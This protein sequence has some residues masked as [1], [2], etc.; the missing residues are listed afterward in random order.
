MT[1]LLE[2]WHA[3]ETPPLDDTERAAIVAVIRDDYYGGWFDGDGERMARAVHPALAKRAFDQD[4]TRS[5]ELWDTTADEMIA[6]AAA[7]H[8]RNRAGNRRVEI[9]VD[10]AGA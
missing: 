2:V 3:S 10:H 5:G 9:T 4:E 7:G 8:G 1:E 6:A